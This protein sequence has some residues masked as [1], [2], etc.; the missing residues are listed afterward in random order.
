MPE[1]L[2]NASRMLELGFLVPPLMTLIS[3][4]KIPITTVTTIIKIVIMRVIIAM[5]ILRNR[6]PKRKPHNFI[7]KHLTPLAD[8]CL[9]G[10][11]LFQCEE[12]TL[13]SAIQA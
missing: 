10:F 11:S 12:F 5:E 8:R 4:E 3:K 9:R 13:L 6:P 2:F 7:K 1:G